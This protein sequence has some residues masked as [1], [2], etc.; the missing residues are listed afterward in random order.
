MLPERDG[1]SV[2]RELREQDDSTPILLLSALGEVDD[3]VTG[4]RAG[5]DDYL[6][7]PYI[8]TELLARVEA[9]GRRTDQGNAQIAA[10]RA[11]K[12]A[13]RSLNPG[14]G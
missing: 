3:K 9:L 10:C 6:A 2:V 7:K 1:L 13:F 14:Y 12:L 4:L 5:G 8:F 11:S